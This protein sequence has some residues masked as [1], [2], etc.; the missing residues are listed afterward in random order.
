MLLDICLENPET[1][2]TKWVD[3]TGVH[4][5]C[6]TYQT[7]ELKAVAKRNL[8]TAAANS[9]SLPDALQYDPS[10]T[11]LDREAKKVEKYS[12]L[13]LMAKK[14]HMD[15]KRSSLPSFVPFVVSDFGELSPA[16]LQ[17]RI[18]EQFRRKCV[19][20]GARANGTSPQT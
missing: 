10:P 9:N 3:T 12:R 11:L 17:E 5:T 18:V 6:L 8:S 19:K 2:E 16:D 15:G 14:Q 7:K 1:G 4:T 20:Q 13:V